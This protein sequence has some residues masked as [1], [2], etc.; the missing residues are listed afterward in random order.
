M[1]KAAILVLAA[2]ISGCSVMAKQE[3]HALMAQI[4]ANCKWHLEN[5]GKEH[6]ECSLARA[7]YEAPARTF[8]GSGHGSTGSAGTTINSIGYRGKDGSYTVQTYV[9]GRLNSSSRFSK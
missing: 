9:N 6:P 7:I 8:S 3:Q 1:F 5:T 2:F 4:E